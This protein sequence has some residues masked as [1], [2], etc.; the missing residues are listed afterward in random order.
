MTRP[1]PVVFV[2]DDDEAVRDS[3]DSLLGSVNLPVKAF[4]SGRAFLDAYR[5]GETGCLVADIRMPGMSGLD[6]QSELARR[7]ID[8]PMIMITGHGDIKMCA[9]AMKAGAFDFVEKPF[10]GQEL[11]DLIHK[12][13]EINL[14]SAG[15]RDELAEIRRRLDQVKPRDR[16]VLDGIVSGETNK[17]IAER[18]ELSAKTVEFRRAKVMRTMQAKTLADLVKMV[19]TLQA[20]ER[21]G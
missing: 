20:A 1:D 2:V 6:L 7:S 5:D 8:L 15:R 3:L 11:L 16:E 14:E 4:A 12:A 18:L 19:M 10:N 9:R 21:N 13:V 17:K